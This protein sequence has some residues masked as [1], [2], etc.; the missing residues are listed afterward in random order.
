M[1]AKKRKMIPY[2]VA[3]DIGVSSVGWA[4]TSSITGELLKFKK[5][6]MWGVRLF[7]EGNTAKERRLSR[8]ARRRLSRKK[9]RIALLKELIGPMIL[10]KDPGFFLRLEKGYM[11]KEDKG[12]NYNLFIENDFNDKTF[13]KKYPTIYHLR[14][15]LCNCKEKTDPRL[16]YLAIHH[17]MKHRGHFLYD[18]KRFDVSDKSETLTVLYKSIN[19]LLQQFEVNE[20]VSLEKISYCL[21]V[22]MNNM[23]SKQKKL[24]VLEN[25]FESF[26]KAQKNL[27]KEYFKCL[28]GYKVNLSKVF[29]HVDFSGWKKDSKFSFSDELSEEDEDKLIY[30]MNDY[31]EVLEQS[32]RVY[33]YIVL[34]DLLRGNT[35]ISKA[36]I[37]IFE[38]HKEDLAE[39]KRIIKTYFDSHTYYKVFKEDNSSYYKCY[40]KQS[41]SKVIKQRDFC[42]KLK[43]LLE[44]N[45]EF[46]NSD[47]AALLLARLDNFDY[48]PKPKSVDNHAIPYQLHKEELIQILNN[49]S[50]YYPL[51]EEN[52]E[53]IISLFEFRVPYYVGPLNPASKK[54]AWII[55]KGEGKIYPWNFEEMVDIDQSAEAFIRRMTNNCTYLLGEPVLAKNSL[56]YSKY[57]VLNELNK[58]RINGKLIGLKEKQQIIDDLFLKEKTITLKRFKE[59]IIQNQFVSSEGE[60]EVSGTQ[61]DD[62]FASSL[63]SWI[64]F[65]KIYGESFESKFE[66]IERLIE[67]ITIF[68]DKK[69]LKRKVLKEIPELKDKI[70][71]I[72]S[73]KFSGWGRFSRKLLKGI[74]HEQGEFHNDIMYYLENTNLNFMQIL[75]NSKYGFATKI[76]QENMME[77]NEITNE[78]IQQIIQKLTTSP[79]N[80]KAIYQ[81]IAVVEEIVKI[82][83]QA[84]ENIFIEFARSNEEKVATSSRKKALEK[85]I[86]DLEEGGS[87]LKELKDL[88]KELNENES[89]LQKRK[90]YLYFLQCGKCLY[91]EKPLDI[92]HLEQYQIDHIIPRAFNDDSLDNVA[93]VCGQEN[94]YKEDKLVLSPLTIKARKL[95]WKKLYDAKMMSQK[96]FYNLCRQEFNDAELASFINRQLVETR[97][98]IKNTA[99]ILSSIYLDSN[100][101]SIKAGMITELR[102]KFN[103]PKNRDLNN[104][105]HAHD[106]YFVS[107]IG[108]YI[109]KKYPSLKKEFVIKKENAVSIVYGD[110]SNILNSKKDAGFIVSQ[111]N[112]KKQKNNQTGEVVWEGSKSIQYLKKVYCYRDCFISYK[113]EESKGAFFDITMVSASKASNKGLPIKK[114]RKDMSKYGR[115]NSVKN[116]YGVVVRY[117][118]G[119]KQICE[120]IDIPRYIAKGGNDTVLRYI[121]EQKGDDIEVVRKILYGQ[122]LIERGTKCL[123]VSSNEKK[124][125]VELLLDYDDQLTLSLLS[126]NKLKETDNVR[127]DSLFQSI[128]KKIE[129]YYPDLY[130]KYKFNMISQKFVDFSFEDKKKFI[131]NA[132]LVGTKAKGK[133]TNVD[134]G[135]LKLSEFGRRKLKINLDDC[136]VVDQSVTGMFEKRIKL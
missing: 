29:F 12:Y 59:Y 101:V 55:R 17:I 89:Q 95:W 30:V 63:Y 110:L 15:W 24:E 93:L 27:L 109:L 70:N 14:D 62:Q 31:Y 66:E 79:A 127:I 22:M 9:Q 36:M 98:I 4:V 119:K 33:D 104:C 96:K 57:E 16:I 84:P 32:K 129:M 118:K 94:Q 43:K 113:A 125:A 35:T 20:G 47:E 44:S 102:K 116:A 34:N 7:D 37:S 41:N 85:M 77:D 103:L 81:A 65:K 40:I 112:D 38:Q 18:V 105:H 83:G 48:L 123:F 67:W 115:Y 1:S 6:N 71:K 54:F 42:D 91:T 61:K 46:M 25:C 99:D 68:E 60:V 106:A 13:Y 75:T 50:K 21:D 53:K 92:N 10:E 90:Y 69:I 121:R 114:D 19:E 74:K 88:K 97:Q 131:L 111:M 3:L 56:L 39:L 11:D 49:Q 64:E 26:D 107:V 78:G 130:R 120:I 5:Q 82:Q 58:V 86:K 76:K 2:N 45:K 122:L 136:V 128:I 51:L 80:K 135:G 133:S 52:K 132:L 73:L 100:V 28:I 72:L 124:N 108:S 87:D 134:I 126:E 23:F 117:K 8:S